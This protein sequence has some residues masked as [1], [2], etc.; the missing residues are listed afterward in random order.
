MAI[1]SA[2]FVALALLSILFRYH[3]MVSGLRH[4]ASAICRA[5]IPL[6]VYPAMIFSFSFKFSIRLMIFLQISS[7]K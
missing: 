7:L 3:F 6:A 5:V 4:M 1:S 2:I